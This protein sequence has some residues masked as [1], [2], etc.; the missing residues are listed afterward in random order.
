V[1]LY[2]TKLVADVNA[3]PF[4]A[5]DALAPGVGHRERLVTGMVAAVADRGYAATTI[6][7]V[8]RHARVSRRTFYEHFPDKEACFL[9]A[10]DAVADAILS[11]IEGAASE[12]SE[13]R[14]RVVAGVRAYL[15]GLALQPVIARVFT[16]DILSAGPRALVR[17]RAVLRRFAASLRGQVDAAAAAG[18]PVRR[19]GDVTALALAG[20]IHELVLDALEAERPE[21][22]AGLEAPI[23]DLVAAVV[24]GPASAEG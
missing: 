7:D 10:Y 9:A 8:V 22:L 24:L 6:T 18:A 19:I 23:A 17:R 3:L 15:Q 2:R 12:P 11:A 21:A 20:A 16:V 1:V 4:P 14:E 13:G 5:P